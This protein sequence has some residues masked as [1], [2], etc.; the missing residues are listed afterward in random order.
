MNYISSSSLPRNDGFGKIQRESFLVANPLRNLL[1][2]KKTLTITN[3]L[4]SFNPYQ[5]R[6]NQYR[7]NKKKDLVDFR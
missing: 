5:L 1:L 3:L 7:M 4:S 6:W 2:T